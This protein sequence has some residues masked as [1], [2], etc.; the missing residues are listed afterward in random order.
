MPMEV[1]DGSN[2][3]HITL[4]AKVAPVCS[5]AELEAFVAFQSSSIVILRLL[6]QLPPYSNEI[7]PQTIVGRCSLPLEIELRL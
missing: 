3:A 1:T 6:R 7:A 5:Y 4:R 2:N